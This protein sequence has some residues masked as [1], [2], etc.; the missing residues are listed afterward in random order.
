MNHKLLN[1]ISIICL[2]LIGLSIMGCRHQDTS[3]VNQNGG[4]EQTIR[5]SGSDTTFLFV[6]NYGGWAALYKYNTAI[7]KTEIVWHKAGEKVI[8]YLNNNETKCGFFL[9]ASETGKL[10]VFPFVHKIKAYV[11]DSVNSVV[12][13][14]TY[15]D[16]VQ[17]MA[18][19]VDKNS[20]RITYNVMDKSNSTFIT[21][22][23][24]LISAEGKQL[25]AE[26]KKFDFTSDGYPLAGAMPIQW[27]S[28]D[29]S[30][31]VFEQNHHALYLA[32]GRDTS[33]VIGPSPF[34]P[35]QLIWDIPH[36]VLVGIIHRVTPENET[37][38]SAKPETAR[39]FVYSLTEK[40]L[41]YSDNGGGFMNA[42]IIG[43]LL[44][45]DTGF[46]K[47]ASIIIHSLLTGKKVNE[48]KI[49]GGC[50]LQDIPQLPDYDA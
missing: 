8:L 20:F 9:T 27:S 10:G 21:Q 49:T 2:A 28:P 24:R 31:T 12:P 11:I 22:K 39:L 13:A 41:L 47:K 48:I 5:K 4:G 43:D 34:T 7:G 37:L 17:V 33:K 15:G 26:N 46:D 40:K 1:Y 18:Q 16:A 29:E 30:T 23:K 45:Y 35:H 38:Y 44:I 25:Y 42:R 50:G 19:W 32:S 3:V 14:G 6:G 36:H